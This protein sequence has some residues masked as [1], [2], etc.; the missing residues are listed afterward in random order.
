MVA[1]QRRVGRG[2]QGRVHGAILDLVG[3]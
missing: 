3:A 2:V 1:V